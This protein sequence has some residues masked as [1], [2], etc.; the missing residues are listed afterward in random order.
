MLFAS[1][2]SKKLE[3]KVV[4]SYIESVLTSLPYDIL[5]VVEEPLPK[6]SVIE[7]YEQAKVKESQYKSV[8]VI[9]A[10]FNDWPL[11]GVAIEGERDTE[12]RLWDKRDF[13]FEIQIINEKTAKS[14]EFIK[15]Y[16]GP[17][18]YVFY[19]SKPIFNSAKTRAMFYFDTSM[20]GVGKGPFERG[21]IV[22]GKRNGKW[23]KLALLWKEMY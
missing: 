10:D 9:P 2:S 20:V 11:D 3:R 13:S 8:Y 21:V 1:C 16:L 15:E 4:N 5:F 17:K 14:I 6:T 23:I 12:P 18:N 7:F 19:I 22:M